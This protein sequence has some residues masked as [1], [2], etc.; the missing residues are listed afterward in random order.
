[1]WCGVYIENGGSSSKIEKL[2]FFKF[3]CRYRVVS[4]ALILR[5]HRPRCRAVFV[6]KREKVGLLILL[7]L[8]LPVVFVRKRE[9][10]GLLIL[11]VLQLSFVFVR[12][13]ERV[14][15]FVLQLSFVFPFDM[16]SDFVEADS[17]RLPR[18]RRL[19]TLSGVWWRP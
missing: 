8:Q 1:M 5:L 9:K 4:P 19:P 14:G 16:P 17:R 18:R 10:V 15:L 3:I 11:F 7:V 2:G 6:R 12:K 13:S